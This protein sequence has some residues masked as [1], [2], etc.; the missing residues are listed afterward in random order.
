[1]HR[2]TD[3]ILRHLFPALLI[4][5]I[6]LIPVACVNDYAD[7]PD[8]GAADN[9][10]RYR[11]QFKI[12][13]RGGLESRVADID[14]DKEGSVAE[15][16]LDVNDI[17]YYLFDGN[18]K[19]L[20][21]ITPNA[22]TVVANEAFTV[23]NVVAEVDLPYFVDNIDNQID[24]YILAFANCS[25]WNVTFP[26]M[27][28]GDDI[29]T[30]FSNGVLLNYRPSTPALLLAATPGVP[31]TERQ[32]F[33]MVGLQRFSIPGSMLLT[34]SEGLP[35]DISLA[36]G[37]NLNMLRAMAKIEIIDK[38]NIP[39]DAVFDAASDNNDVRIKDV[40][41]NGF[42]SSA[43]LLP[44]INIWQLNSTFETQQVIGASIPASPGYHLPPALNA[45]NTI[46]EPGTLSDY[47]M[48]FAYDETATMQR[49]DK[50][51]VYSCYIYEYSRASLGTVP[52][53]QQPYFT[54]TTS[55][56]VDPDGEVQVEPLTFP[57]RMAWY[58]NGVAT[59]ADNIPEILRNH[60]YRF[61][62][63]GI[64]QNLTVN[65]TVCDMDQANASIEFN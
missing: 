3:D 64:H 21:D 59:S 37:N 20:T 8:P 36:T 23:Y 48:P 22:T 44:I 16:Y 6:A 41:I 62:I 28:E 15:N 10:G 63:S 39:D 27:N 5:I 24:F 18:R 50:C 17:R 47:S 1:M 30:L 2:I 55:E 19:Y 32:R 60:I 56:Y 34:T 7:C 65:W 52:A 43:R 54:V 42:N 58:Q 35:F 45:D 61:E 51:P 25:G 57:M 12:V 33:P 26:V 9:P 38:I 4:A 40:Q 14:G 49:R 46:S 53:T 31:A 29:S 11:L 13:T